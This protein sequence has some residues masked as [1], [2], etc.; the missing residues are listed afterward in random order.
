MLFFSYNSLADFGDL[1][2]RTRSFLDLI[3]TSSNRF[4][5]FQRCKTWVR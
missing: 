4:S 5:H 3:S 1:D 2:T